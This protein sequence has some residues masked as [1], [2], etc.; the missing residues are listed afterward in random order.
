MDFKT[1]Y[2]LSTV[3]TFEL[4]EKKVLIMFLVGN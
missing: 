3:D 2:F 1:C 4:K